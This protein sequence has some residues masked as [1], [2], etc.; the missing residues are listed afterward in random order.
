VAAEVLAQDRSVKSEGHLQAAL[1][2]C[3]LDL[4]RPDLGL[5][6]LVQGLVGL[7]LGAQRRGLLDLLLIGGLG[8]TPRHQGY[9]Q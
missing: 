5:E 7:I 3:D 9:R 2:L 8:D 6:L 4:I 1:E